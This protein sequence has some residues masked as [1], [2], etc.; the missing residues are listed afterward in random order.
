MKRLGILEALTLSAVL[1]L[2]GLIVHSPHND[3]PYPLHVDEWRHI[4]GAVH[5]LDGGYGS[6]DTSS[7]EIGYHVFL[8]L[9]AKFGLDLIHAFGFLPAVYAIATGLALFLFVSRLTGGFLASI[10]SVLFF[11]A[12]P[13]N[14]NLLGLWFATPMTFT[15]PLIY[16]FFMV[17]QDTVESW[18]KKK[19]IISAA[20]LA[21]MAIVYPPSAALTVSVAAVYLLSK[22]GG[23]KVPLRLHGLVA[24][25]GI[26]VLVALVSSM[27]LAGRDLDWLVSN[28]I[29]RHGWTPLEPDLTLNSA[30]IDLG[31]AELRVH[32]YFIPMLFG[33]VPF[34]LSMIGLIQAYTD[35]RLGI[36][37]IWVYFTAGLIFLFV[38][39]GFSPL[40]PYQRAV[41][42]CLLGLAPLAGIG[43]SRLLSMILTKSNSPVAAAAAAILV[44]IGTFWGYGNLPA[45]L[46]VYH[47]IG[48][49]DIPASAFL[50][51]KPE[52]RVLSTL[53]LGSALPA[54]SGKRVVADVAFVGDEAKRGAVREFFDADCGRKSEILS[55]YQV[56][57]V[58]SPIRLDCP[59]LHEDYSGERFIYSYSSR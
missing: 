57:Y 17:F 55:T 9:M 19:I 36:P 45:G 53:E 25:C 34:V 4:G 7:F 49:G 37:A 18:P 22:R 44:F 47:V 54:L 12:L 40:I 11:A 16:L 41:Y 48:D 1:A 13:S 5:L 21:A 58:Y 20:L 3:Y 27:V 30:K 31:R 52:G 50:K 23:I 15:F 42:Y 29:F 6:G 46:D 32:I 35:D 38:N 59:G 2:T 56:K 39:F 14:T 43:F 28:I 24:V 33:A 8:G 26:L 51:A 10:S